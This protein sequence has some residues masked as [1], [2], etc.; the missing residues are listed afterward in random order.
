VK[1]IEMEFESNHAREQAAW[2]IIAIRKRIPEPVLKSTPTL[3]IWDS[4][5]EEFEREMKEQG[6]HYRANRETDISVERFVE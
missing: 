3:M 4:E 2:A 5:R 1:L 6:V